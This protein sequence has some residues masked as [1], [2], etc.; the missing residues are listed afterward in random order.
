MNSSMRIVIYGAQGIALGAYNA[1]K[2]LQPDAVVE[3]FLVTQRGSNASLLGK[4]PV[5]ELLEF[6]ADHTDPEK[7]N[8]LVLIATP[9]IVMAAIERNLDEAGLHNYVRLD[10]L[11]WAKMQE[12]AFVKKGIF[13][14]L[15]AYVPGNRKPE[16]HIFKMCHEKDK[17]LRTQYQDPDYVKRLQVGAAAAAKQVASLQDNSGDHIS[18]KNGNYS[19]LT[20]LYW[21]WKNRIRKK[22]SLAEGYFGLSHYRR[23][24][25]LSE[26]DLVRLTLNNI[27][28]VL[29]YPMP[30]EPNIEAHHL[31][32]LSDAEWNAVLRA[33]DELQPV[34]A[35]EFKK[36][37]EQ[38]YLYNYNMILAKAEVLNDY[39]SWL[40]PLLFRIEELADSDG[41]KQPNR[42]IGYVGET[43]ETLYFMYN[44]NHLK[45]AHTGCRFLC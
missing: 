20:G 16:I 13:M 27:D 30:Y 12:L 33:L 35:D 9:E 22:D 44:R 7:G 45:I 31:R 14:P 32:Y 25:E 24:F 18:L 3:C 17:A 29:P 42:Y 6:V 5:R 34:Y 4:L 2:I 10:S 37:L 19:E 41:K 8:F 39:C 28:V 1:I 21:M 43:L 36:I 15:A 11:R 38:Q 23:F 40:F 26:D